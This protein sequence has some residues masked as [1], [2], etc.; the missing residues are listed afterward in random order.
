[1]LQRYISAFPLAENDGMTIS[2]ARGRARQKKDAT[3]VIID[4]DSAVVVFFTYFSPFEKYSS[5][6]ISLLKFPLK[7]E[8]CGEEYSLVECFSSTIL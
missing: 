4:P 8:N 2:V 7:I 5:F 6:S 3:I 1:M